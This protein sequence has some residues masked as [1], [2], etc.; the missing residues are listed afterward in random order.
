M[1]RYT[2]RLPLGHNTLN[3]YTCDREIGKPGAFHPCRRSADRWL[4]YQYVSDDGIVLGTSTFH[5]CERHGH[6]AWEERRK[7]PNRYTRLDRGFI[8]KLAN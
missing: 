3:G 1:E 7:E 2:T 8:R 5:Y 4:T 6:K